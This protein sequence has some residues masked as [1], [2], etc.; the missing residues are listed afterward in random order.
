MMLTGTPI[1][2]RPD[3]LIGLL[4]VGKKL[5]DFHGEEAFKYRYMR[6]LSKDSV[7]YLDSVSRTEELQRRINKY[8]VRR[9]WNSLGL[10]AYPYSIH[11]EYI[12]TYTGHPLAS[13]DICNIEHTEKKI[14]QFKQQRC[15]NWIKKGLDKA[16]H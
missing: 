16:Y 5:Q 14:V 6:E 4:Y 8:I 9:T 7:V 15:I 13:R 1:L 3:D 11:Q 12:G 2:N 10:P